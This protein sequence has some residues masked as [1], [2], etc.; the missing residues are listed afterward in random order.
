MIGYSKRA[1]SALIYLFRPYNDLDVF[2]E[3]EASRNLY[4]VLINR[5]LA[6]RAAVNRV[7]QLGPR[8]SVIEACEADQDPRD[9]KRIYIIDGD[10]DILDEVP[11]PR[12]VHL[13]RLSVYSSENLVVSPEALLEVAYECNPNESRDELRAR[14]NLA[15]FLE[16]LRD[17]LEPLLT[18][19]VVAH[20]NDD[21]IQTMGYNATLLMESNNQVLELSHEKVADRVA[22]IRRNLESSMDVEQ[23]QQAVQDVSR[24]IGSLRG[25]SLQLLSGKTHVIPLIFHFLHQHASYRGTSRELVLRMSRHCDIDVDPRLSEAVT[26][27]ARGEYRFVA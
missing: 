12:L 10:F 20:R 5:I 8:S 6:P 27:A 26:Q 15:Q 22:E 19:Y 7:F 1:I 3:D 13:Y 23:V 25:A 17:L 11:R 21:S 16:G 14:L 9:R 4:E 24:M 18:I 2:V